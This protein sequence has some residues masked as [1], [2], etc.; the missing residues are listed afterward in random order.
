MAQ[1]KARQRQHARYLY[2]RTALSQKAI[3]GAVG[4]SERS[5]YSWIRTEKWAEQKEAT[6]YSPEQEIHQLFEQLRKRNE[7]IAL[8]PDGIATKEDL[9]F[10]AKIAAL[11]AVYLKNGPASWR[12]IAAEYDLENKDVVD[13]AALSALERR[14]L[15]KRRKIAEEDAN[16]EYGERFDPAYIHK[17]YMT[18]ARDKFDA[19]T[20]SATIG[21]DGKPLP[22]DDP[23]RMKWEERIRNGQ[24]PFVDD[25][26][27]EKDNNKKDEDDDIG[28][29]P[30]GWQF[31]DD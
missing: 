1:R 24:N 21:K 4:V 23:Q 29:V 13:L 12:N 15:E 30:E 22:P 25:E 27:D 2:F 26:D 11:I 9:D 18:I 19:D 14:N 5:L 8:R 17:Y 16:A 3:A 28:Y 7:V 20:H 31:T 10:K 6:Y